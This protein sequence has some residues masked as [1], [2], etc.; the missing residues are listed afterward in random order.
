MPLHCTQINPMGNHAT[1]TTKSSTAHP[2]AN[3][4]KL[5][6]VPIPNKDPCVLGP[7]RTR[8]RAHICLP[9]RLPVAPNSRHTR[10][11]PTIN[12]KRTGEELCHFLSKIGCEQSSCIWEAIRILGLVR[13]QGLVH[14]L[15]LAGFKD[16]CAYV[17][18]LV[19]V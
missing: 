1:F 14:I 18:G 13:I 10:G 4:G 2:R 9:R 7:V 11:C 17:L 12:A 16:S 3:G 19:R 6:H 15:G 8:T 5:E